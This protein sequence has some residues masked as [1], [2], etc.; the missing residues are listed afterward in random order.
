MGSVTTVEAVALLAEPEAGPEIYRPRGKSP[1]YGCA[2]EKAR[3]VCP[4]W[5][6]CHLEREIGES[7]A[8]E[9]PVDQP[10][11]VYHDD[12]NYL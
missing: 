7:V 6:W 9:R 2:H 4:F 8:C 10:R 5:A 3:H 1:W 12:K 11:E